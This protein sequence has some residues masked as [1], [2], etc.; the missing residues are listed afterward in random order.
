TMND[1]L[2][3]LSARLQHIRE[4]ER[5]HIAREMH[6]ELGQMLT[7]F[8]MDVS[9]LHRRIADS[10]EEG[11]NERLESLKKLVDE[12]VH[13][14]RRL[15][16]ELRPSVLDDLGLVAA[17]EWHSLEF[18]KR[19]NINVSFKADQ[20]NLQVPS[21]VGIGLFRIYQESLT[22]VARHASA[23]NVTATLESAPGQV[24]LSIMDD[25]KGFDMNST[26]NR[27]TLGLLGMRERAHMIGG[28]LD[29]ISSP[30]KGTAVIITVP[31]KQD[32]TGNST[33]NETGKSVQNEPRA[34]NQ[35]NSEPGK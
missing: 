5:I 9:W 14:V 7:G 18:Q 34:K 23:Q 28:Q 35:N 15:A 24:C 12:A 3:S 4:Q 13:F 6:D 8:K 20:E 21:E 2:R 31:L 29:I 19:F 16:A 22:N 26:G 32:E 27:K 10:T 30:G 17:L 33:Q 11:V 25:G 1:E